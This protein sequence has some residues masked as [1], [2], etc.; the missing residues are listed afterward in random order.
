[1]SI[2]DIN[3]FVLGLL[4]ADISKTVG[5]SVRCQ[6]ELNINST[7]AFEK[8]K[9]RGSSPPPPQESAPPV[10]RVY[11]LL[12]HLFVTFFVVQLGLLARLRKSVTLMKISSQSA[13]FL[14]LFRG[15][16]DMCPVQNACR[17]L[18]EEK[19]CLKRH[20]IWQECY[21]HA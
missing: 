9:S 21:R 19:K 13:I 5:R 12:T 3:S 16:T 6:L 15:D 7:R 18:H 4:T 11:A 20:Y 10:W 1:M 2:P 8:C 14:A 17:G